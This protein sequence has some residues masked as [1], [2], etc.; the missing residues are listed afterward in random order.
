MVC[1][2]QYEG[3]THYIVVGSSE[4]GKGQSLRKGERKSSNKAGNVGTKVVLK[5]VS[6]V[7]LQL[8]P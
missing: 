4:Y 5:L 8:N 3:H 2:L 1:V 6:N 7:A